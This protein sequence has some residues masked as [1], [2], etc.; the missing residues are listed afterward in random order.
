MHKVLTRTAKG[1]EALKEKVDSS[2]VTY[3][4]APP[5]GAESGGQQQQQQADY[6]DEGDL[7]R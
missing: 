7:P 4:S 2:T 5:A 6:D 1:L 3:P